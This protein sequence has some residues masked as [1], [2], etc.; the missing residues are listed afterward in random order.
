MNIRTQR[1]LMPLFLDSVINGEYLIP[2]FQR[3]FIWTPKQ[4]IDLFDSILKGFPI[5]SIIM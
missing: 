1:D 4:I 2:K 5:G 3:D